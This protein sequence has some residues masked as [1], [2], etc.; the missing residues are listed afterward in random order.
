ME[1]LPGLLRRPMHG[2]SRCPMHGY[3]AGVMLQRVFSQGIL[4]AWLRLCLPY[5]SKA[6]LLGTVCCHVGQEG[7][8]VDRG[9][10]G[11]RHARALPRRAKGMRGKGLRGEGGYKGGI[12]GEAEPFEVAKGVTGWRVYGWKCARALAWWL[13]CMLT[14]GACRCMAGCGAIAA[15]A[16]FAVR[17]KRRWGIAAARASRCNGPAPCTNRRFRD[18]DSAAR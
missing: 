3:S 13:G 17:Q 5:C 4:A 7:G 16:I 1:L 14:L 18:A 15:S 2:Q 10:I 6:W 8:W 9:R 12:K 11:S